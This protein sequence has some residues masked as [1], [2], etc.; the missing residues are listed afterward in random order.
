MHFFFTSVVFTHSKLSDIVIP[1][2]TNL[3][4]FLQLNFLTMSF[5]FSF[6]FNFSTM[7]VGQSDTQGYPRV[8]FLV[9]YE[10][11]ILYRTI[12][13]NRT[14]CDDGTVLYLHIATNPVWLLKT[15]K[16]ASVTEEL[17]FKFYLI[18]INFALNAHMVASGYHIEQHRCSTHLSIRTS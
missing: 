1:M 16:V 11:V 13:P 17:S 7:A 14:F 2:V 18:L 6:F 10:N 8:A 5:V 4:G 12:L 15:W 3:V 9:Q